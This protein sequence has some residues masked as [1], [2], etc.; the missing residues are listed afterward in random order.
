M[1]EVINQ[2][3]EELQAY[4][5]QYIP[6]LALA[7]LVPLTILVFILPIDILS[8]VILLV[9]APLIPLFMVLIGDRAKVLTDE[10]WMALSRMS[11]YFLDVI[12][13][14]GTLKIFGRSKDQV[15]IINEVGERYRSTT[16]G[17]LRVT[18]L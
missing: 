2:G 10:R 3:I 13:G 16:L 14:L 8:G 11:A 7:V 9:T 4:F 6:Q 15:H 12:Q 18:F 1:L 5:G 17:V